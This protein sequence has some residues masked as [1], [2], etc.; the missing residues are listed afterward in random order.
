M[1]VPGNLDYSEKLL[2]GVFFSPFHFF[3]NILIEMWCLF[4]FLEVH[5][6]LKETVLDLVTV[7][8]IVGVLEGVKV[9]RREEHQQ[10]TSLH[11]R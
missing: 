1:T 6:A 11:F 7:M 3:L 5:L 2:I 10:I 8:V 4:G 9:V